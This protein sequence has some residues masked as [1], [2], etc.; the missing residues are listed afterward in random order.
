[1]PTTSRREAGVASATTTSPPSP[2]VVQDAVHAAMAGDDTALVALASPFPGLVLEWGFPA[3]CLETVHAM[4]DRGYNAW[5]FDADRH[6]AL[7]SWHQQWGADADPVYFHVQANGLDRRW[8][9]IEA[10]Y[11][12]HLIRTLAADGAYLPVAEIDALIFGT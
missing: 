3:A 11:G 8:Q 2:P 12:G 4:I 1:M 7:R 5:F 6:A 10:A 9:E